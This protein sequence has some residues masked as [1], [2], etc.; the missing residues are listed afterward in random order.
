M[1]ARLF[2]LHKQKS[3]KIV[4]DHNEKAGSVR[5]TLPALACFAAD[6]AGSAYLL[7]NL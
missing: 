2:G 7:P 1:L 6:A 5:N 4:I 3:Q